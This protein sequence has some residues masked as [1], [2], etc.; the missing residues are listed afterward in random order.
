MIAVVVGMASEAA[1]IGQ[2]SDCIVIIGAGDA[3]ALTAKLE[4]AI[5]A[6]ATSVLS[7]GIC[8]ALAPDMIAGEVVIG[9]SVSYQL[10]RIAVDFSW[11]NRLLQLLPSAQM[12]RFAW[13][14]TAVARLADK[15]ALRR[16]VGADVVDEETFLA[17]SLAATHGIPWVALRAVSD[18]ANFELPPAALVKLTA[19]GKD[20][21]SAILDSIAGD[22]WQIP[23]LMELG[24]TTAYAMKNL[25]TALARIG[26]NFSAS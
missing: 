13:S 11:A 8:G 3:K 9:T 22:I 17:A 24:A 20:N 14:N 1:L 18:G 10:S 26:N 25:K 15:A 6:G 7:F 16:A 4:A 23:E 2:R 5:V 21:M 19:A 12:A